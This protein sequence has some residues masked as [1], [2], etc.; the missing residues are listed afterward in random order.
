VVLYGGTDKYVA[1]PD[2]PAWQISGGGPGLGVSGSGDVQA[3]VV[4]GLL[5]RGA[6]PE[7]AAVWGGFV[8][9][10]LGERLTTRVGRLGYLARELPGVVPE[11]LAELEA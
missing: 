11:V 2:G 9:A 3:G 8:H 1:S 10:T 7:Q 6:E 4:A 5:A